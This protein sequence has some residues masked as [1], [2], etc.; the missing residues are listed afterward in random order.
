[1]R[2][3]NPL[4]AMPQ[5]QIFLLAMAFLM[6]FVFSVWGA[7]LNNFVVEKANF[8]GAE[9]GVLQSIREIPGFL[10]FTAIYVLLFIKEQRFA[11]LSLG[12]MSFGVAITGFFPSEYGLYLTTLIMSVGF[13]YFETTQQ[14]LTLQWLPKSDTAHFMGKS[15]AMKSF[16]SLLA[17]GG[18]LT[19]SHL[20]SNEEQSE[21]LISDGPYLFYQDESK[22]KVKAVTIKAVIF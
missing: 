2:F 1:M 10:A 13:H 22:T 14:S 5:P 15:L 6:P 20:Y 19:A 3:S 21:S 16:A 12:L 18:I 9:I 4:S 17:F 7:L 8:T 11:L